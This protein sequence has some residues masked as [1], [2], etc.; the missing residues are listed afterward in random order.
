MLFASGRRPNSDRL[1]VA[2]AG[3]KMDARGRVLTDDGMETNVPGIFAFGDLAS[4]HPLKHVANA[5]AWA[6][7]RHL[8]DGDKQP[9]A[10]DG[11]PNAVFSAPQVASVGLTER[12][13]VQ[14]GPPV[15]DDTPPVC[16]H[17]LRLG[18]E[19]HR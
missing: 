2:A 3:I 19:R 7:A 1:N 17:R 4:R 8:L 9:V 11:V 16:R 15:H 14:Q 18:H 12:D 5:E 10:Y 6:I 13:A